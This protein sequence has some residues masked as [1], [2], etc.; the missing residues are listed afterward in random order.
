MDDMFET[1]LLK[2]LYRG[3]LCSTC[4][5]TYCMQDFCLMSYEMEE[6]ECE[7]KPNP[8]GH[9][10]PPMKLYVVEDVLYHAVKKHGGWEKFKKALVKQAPEEEDR[11]MR[12]SE[13]QRQRASFSQSISYGFDFDVPYSRKRVRDEV[14]SDHQPRR[15]ESER[16]WQD[17]SCTK[18]T[19]TCLEDVQQTMIDGSTPRC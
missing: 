8:H 1:K 4:C 19:L 11:S 2:S 14:Y 12:M 10:K 3:T 9:Q 5:K 15:V 6:L 18:L 7:L 13:D 17:M 16:M